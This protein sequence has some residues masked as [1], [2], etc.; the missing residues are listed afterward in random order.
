LRERFPEVV[1]TQPELLAHH[2]TEAGLI[3]QAIPYWQKAIER[4]AHVEAVGHLTKGLELLKTLP[5]TPERTQQELLLCVALGPALIAS[6]GYASPDTVDVYTQARALCQQIGETPQLFSALWG[7]MVVYLVQPQYSL[8]Y[9]LGQQL[10]TLAQRTQDSALLMEAHYAL[11]LSSLWLGKLTLAL[12]H[13]ERSA[14]FCNPQ[15]HRAHT[16]L[17]GQ[18]SGGT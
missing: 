14:E 4:S 7:L 18:V 17:Y 11:G 12:E 3:A 8:A 6:K 9:E 5:D 10:L 13:A 1:E 16:L 15:H 2:Y